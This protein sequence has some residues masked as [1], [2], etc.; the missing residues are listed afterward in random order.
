MAN[1]CS[2]CGAVLLPSAQ[3][4]ISCGAQLAAGS[5]PAPAQSVQLLGSVQLA[6]V[7]MK[8]GVKF[9][10]ILAAVGVGM[11]IVMGIFALVLW[12][13]FRHFDVD[14]PASNKPALTTEPLT[15]ADLGVEIYP[16]A[17]YTKGDS[18]LT[19]PDR[20]STAALYLTSDSK[21]QVLAFY[22]EKLGSGASVIDTLDGSIITL[23]KSEQE[24][25]AV[26]IKA[27]PSEYSGKTQITIVHTTTTKS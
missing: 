25:V 22:R 10:L 6:D 19:H 1:I 11:T 2:R 8:K 16:G 18:H 14:D 21:D 7:V 24:Q 23:K 17:Q 20:T 12:G 15:A 26:T 3:F 5:A 27:D 13:V 9:I 4:C